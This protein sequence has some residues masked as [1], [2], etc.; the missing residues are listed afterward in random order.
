M[1]IRGDQIDW[2]HPDQVTVAQQAY[3]R[4]LEELRE[5]LNRHL[6]L[7]LITQ[8]A[9]Y[10]LYPPQTCYQR[11]LDRFQDAPERTV[12]TVFYLNLDWHAEEGGQL[13]LHLAERLQDLL[14]SRNRLVL[15]RSVDIQHEVL[16]ATRERLSIICW[17]RYRSALPIPVAHGIV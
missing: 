6:Y 15:F 3:L 10:A 16:L 4:R 9:H 5:L 14:L 17:L 7:S 8:E 12:S 13:C 1:R 11:H 2:W